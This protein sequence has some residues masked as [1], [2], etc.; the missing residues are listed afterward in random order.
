MGLRAQPFS[1][2]PSSADGMVT[3]SK[4]KAVFQELCVT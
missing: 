3:A 2:L 1:H 4:A